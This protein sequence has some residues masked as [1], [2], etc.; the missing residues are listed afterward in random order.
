[1]IS[2]NDLTHTDFAEVMRHSA[3]G[4]LSDRDGGLVLPESAMCRFYSAI[5]LP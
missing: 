4:T 1:M 3:L 5:T 2:I